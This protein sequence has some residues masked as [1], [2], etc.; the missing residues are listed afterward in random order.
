MLILLSKAKKSIQWKF[1]LLTRFELES[2]FSPIIKK[3][4][5][6]DYF[7]TIFLVFVLLF[8]I[9]YFRSCNLTKENK[10]NFSSIDSKFLCKYQVISVFHNTCCLQNLKITMN[11][12]REQ[13]SQLSS[14]KF[15]DKKLEQFFCMKLFSKLI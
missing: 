7:Q 15:S 12:C 9:W 5:R 2:I 14:M 6:I 13:N 3:N 1:W 11:W 4:I 10:Q 8:F